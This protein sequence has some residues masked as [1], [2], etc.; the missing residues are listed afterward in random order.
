M[1]DINTEKPT[2]KTA[3][4]KQEWCWLKV[5]AKKRSSAGGSKGKDKD[6][7]DDDDDGGDHNDGDCVAMMMITMMAVL[8]ARHYSEPHSQIVT[9]R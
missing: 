2:A 7:D 3:N 1:R 6:K 8:M 5:P 4:Y 9:Q